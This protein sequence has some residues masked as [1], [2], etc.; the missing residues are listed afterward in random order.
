MIVRSTPCGE[1]D[2]KTPA[3]QAVLDLLDLLRRVASVPMM[4]I[5]RPVTLPCHFRSPGTSA[6]APENDR[7]GLGVPTVTLICCGRPKD[8]GRPDDYAAPEQSPRRSPAP[9]GRRSTRMKLACEGRKPRPN[10]GKPR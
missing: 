1:M 4:M 3:A 9:P 8:A 10:A 5:I 7:S 6:R 2:V